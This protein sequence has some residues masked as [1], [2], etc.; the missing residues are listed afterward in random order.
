MSGAA[1][2]GF[3]ITAAVLVLI[4]FVNQLLPAAPIH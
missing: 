2:R 3:L 4:G 1:L